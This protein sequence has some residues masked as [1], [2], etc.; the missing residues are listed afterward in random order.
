MT[1]P[2]AYMMSRF[3]QLSETFILREMIE[4][5]QLGYQVTLYPLIRQ[6]QPIVHSSAA[7]W[8]TRAN[9]LPIFSRQGLRYQAK[10]LA[11]LPHHHV[12]LWFQMVHAHLTCPADLVRALILFPKAVQAA[13]RMQEEGV[14]H[15]H[16]HFATYPALVAWLIHRLT[17]IPYSVTAHA[18]DIFVRTTMLSTKLRDAAFI[19]A[20]STYNLDHLTRQFG[21]S[22]RPKTHVIHCGIT[23][24]HYTPIDI[25]TDRQ[26]PSRFEII[27]IGSLQPYKGYP[28]LIQACAQLRDRGLSFRCRI[29]GGGAEQSKL[30]H[31]IRSHQL[32]HHVELLGPQPQEKIRDLLP[33][34]H[35]YVQPS[36]IMPSGKMEGIPVSLMEALACRLPVVATHL[37]GIPELVQPGRTG[38]LVAPGD[39]EALAT[40]IDRVHRE[41]EIAAE[42]AQRGRDLVLQEFNLST[43]VTA[44]ASLFD[45]VLHRADHAE[46]RYAAAI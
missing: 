3:P 25:A 44:L 45:D 2:I 6:S 43:N 1:G 32:Q 27:S 40:T 41:P 46:K 22:I 5:E 38:H 23:P 15:I 42:M 29:I 36:V 28:T 24:A 10:A 16:A 34:A 26:P 30:T 7:D 4:L 14:R 11:R 33:T 31:L 12:Q 21:E 19:V 39:A 37:S 9:A 8:I 35:C 20:I 17:G 13:Q 18:H